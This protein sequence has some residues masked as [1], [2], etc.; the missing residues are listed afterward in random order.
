[1]FASLF[2][3]RIYIYL[4]EYIPETVVVRSFVR[5]CHQRCI[6]RVTFSE[7]LLGNQEHPKCSPVQTYETIAHIDSPHHFGRMFSKN[8]MSLETKIWGGY[9]NLLSF[10][11]VD[12]GF[13]EVVHF[14]G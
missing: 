5:K 10:L 4:G 1:M 7:F 6:T 14:L 3:S 13:F 12:G 2:K 11:L 8:N 9:C